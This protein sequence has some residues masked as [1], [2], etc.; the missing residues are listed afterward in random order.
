LNTFWSRGPFNLLNFEFKL[1]TE[2][3]DMSQI[4]TPNGDVIGLKY[5]TAPI[6]QYF[7]LINDYPGKNWS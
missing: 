3:V 5:P 7:T 4:I 6:N 1:L 2:S